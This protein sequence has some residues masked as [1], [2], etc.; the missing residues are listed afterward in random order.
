MALRRVYTKLDQ[1]VHHNEF[2]SPA[3]CDLLRN[4]ASDARAIARAAIARAQ[5]EEE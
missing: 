1:P 4:S 3:A 2:R 5:G